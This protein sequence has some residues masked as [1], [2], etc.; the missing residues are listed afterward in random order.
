[1]GRRVQGKLKESICQQ[2]PFVCACLQAFKQ[3]TYFNVILIEKK[4]DSRASTDSLVLCIGWKQ[5]PN[6]KWE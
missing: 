6:M 1:M 2:E 5:G 4:T 3:A